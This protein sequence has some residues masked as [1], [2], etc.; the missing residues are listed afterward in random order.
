MNKK[1]IERMEDLLNERWNIFTSHSETQERSQYYI[2]RAYYHG[3]IQSLETMGYYW[4]RNKSGKH[5][6]YK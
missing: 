1:Q 4:E 2:E 5:L 3:L 6:V